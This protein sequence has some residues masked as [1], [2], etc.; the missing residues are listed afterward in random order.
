M[1]IIAQP[2]FERSAKKLHPHEKAALDDAVKAIASNPEIG[3]QKKAIWSGCA[4][5]NIAWGIACYCW[6]TD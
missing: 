5:I 2:R 3:E 6:R 1:R 4:Y